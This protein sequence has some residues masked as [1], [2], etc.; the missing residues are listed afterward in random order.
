MLLGISIVIFRQLQSI[1]DGR[2]YAQLNNSSSNRNHH[3]V[4]KGDYYRVSDKTDII[5]AVVPSLTPIH[6]VESSANWKSQERDRQ[7]PED[8]DKGLQR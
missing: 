3:E 8:K 5:A 4:N 7:Q 2:D 6:E 1:H